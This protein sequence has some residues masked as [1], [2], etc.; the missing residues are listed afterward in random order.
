VREEKVVERYHG[1][2]R[3]DL[4]ALAAEAGVKGRSRM[5]KTQLIEALLKLAEAVEPVSEQ[6]AASDTPRTPDE[7]PPPPVQERTPELPPLLGESRLVLLPQG[8]KIAFAYWE[9][10]GDA[11][12][13]GLVLKVMSIQTGIGI[14]LHE[15]AGR[16]GSYYIRL[17]QSGQ[18]IEAILGNQTGGEFHQML[19]SNRIRLPD[20]SPSE[21][22]PTLWM[23]RRKD[24]EE[25]YRLS[26]G[27]QETGE[28]GWAYEEYRKGYPIFSWPGER[29]KDLP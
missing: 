3:N 6:I 5:T 16:T 26:V 24:Y 13:G 29:K 19:R 27:G 9:L 23:T 2:K 20:D 10:T 28:P 22:L 11:V 12:P 1:M 15:I 14:A 8:P 17:D 18:E 7:W 4:L 25:I 21:E